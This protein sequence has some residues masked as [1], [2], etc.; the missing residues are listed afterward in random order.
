[1][2]ITSG[3]ELVSGYRP[4]LIGA[5]TALH[6]RH[7]AA[8]AGFGCAFEAIV[9]TGL[10]AFCQRLDSPANGLWTLVED[11]DILG[12]IAI[13]GEDLG[14]GLAHL[15]WFILAERLRGGGHGRRL[16]DAALSFADARG[17]AETH[18]W[19]FAGLDAARRLYE[20]SG[21][22]LA[23]ERPGA[24]W[25]Q[26]VREQRFVRTRGAGLPTG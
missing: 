8:A 6:A 12:S 22:T 19:T 5:V 10:S 7:Y 20:R 2:S 13:D 11:G 18:L 25:G 26:E 15:R 14:G 21:F 16:L 23:E 17:H 3:P 9:A 4:G 1:M 24:Q